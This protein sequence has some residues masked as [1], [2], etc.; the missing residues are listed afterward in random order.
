MQS[1]LNQFV[2]R[3]RQIMHTAKSFSQLLPPADTHQS[4][5]Q[6]PEMYK[7]KC[8]PGGDISEEIHE[9]VFRKAIA[10]PLM[11]KMQNHNI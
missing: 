3:K 5:T 4:Y 11:S 8:Q 9:S 1:A 2:E 6:L 7:K 10:A